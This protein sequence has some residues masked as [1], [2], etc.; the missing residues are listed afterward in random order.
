MYDGEYRGLAPGIHEF[1]VFLIVAEVL[2][3]FCVAVRCRVWTFDVHRCKAM[4]CV[5]AKK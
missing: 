3:V 4:E 1:T 2:R 5:F